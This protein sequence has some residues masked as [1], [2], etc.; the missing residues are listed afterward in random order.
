MTSRRSDMV[1]SLKE[2]AARLEKDGYLV[3]EREYDDVPVLGL[4]YDSRQVSAG[5]L[6]VCKG[7]HFRTE[8]LQSALNL[9]AV[10]YVSET[11]YG[12]PVPCL[13]VTDVRKAMV[14]LAEVFYDNAP[15]KL[16]I[17]GITGTKGKS[18]TTYYV[19]AILDRFCGRECAVF[20]S[21]DNYD[22]I[23]RE[24][25]HLTTQEAM[26]IHRRCANALKSGITH[27]V[28]EVSSQALKYDRVSGMRFA[29]GAF[30][31]IGTDH[32][33]PIEHADF[34]D[35]F[36][37]KLKIFSQ[38]DTAVVNTSCE[39]GHE[40]LD[41]AVSDCRSVLT[42][43][44]P[45][46]DF[47]AENIV[48]S[49]DGI[50][51]DV[52]SGGR[53]YPMSICMTGLFNV[54]NALCACA[55][56]RAVGVPF[57]TISLGLAGATAP[58]RMEVFSS[59]D[60]RK[61]VIVD[62][63]H[64][65]LSFDALYSSAAKEYTGKKIV[66]VFGCPGKKALGRRSELPESAAP[67]ASRLIITEEDSGEEPFGEIAADIAAASKKAGC[68]YYVI[69]DR[70]QAVK[71]AVFDCGDDVVIL[72]TGKGRETRMKRGTAY[73]DTP[74]DVDYTLKYLEEYNRSNGEKS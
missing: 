59:L 67:Y 22:G 18:T 73:I 34:D 23:E 68:P 61:T 37:S 72:L 24:E 8:Y 36:K 20:S 15:S 62:Y 39:H 14:S 17:I 32:I 9:G 50:S 65:R 13:R 52:V 27:L 63:A 42:F 43:G 44:K 21:I 64:N 51:F 71:K 48:P 26:E 69:E 41:R 19:K 11:D 53:K 28:M 4:T 56:C 3:R 30:L 55:L 33:S 60:G 12:L 58:G 70:E 54:Q 49:P 29:A 25:S 66:G 5:T 1:H 7:A 10:A 57:E 46:D 35:Y 40:I 16:T 31:N 38:C 6:F 45:G 2:F 74:S 47:Y